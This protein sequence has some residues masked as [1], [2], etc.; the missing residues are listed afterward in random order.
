MAATIT[1]AKAQVLAAL[2]VVVATSKVLVRER[3]DKV[4]TAAFTAK[5][6]R[7]PEKVHIP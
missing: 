1:V 4:I 2:A 6:H 7:V 5:P 3:L